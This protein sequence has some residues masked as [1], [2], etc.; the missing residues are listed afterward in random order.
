[1]VLIDTHCHLND[2]PLVRDVPAVL[3]RAR[4]SGVAQVI[5]PAYDQDSWAVVG[6]LQAQPGVSIALGLHPWVATA[7]GDLGPAAAPFYTCKLREALISS[8]AVAVGEIGLD[9]KIEKPDRSA[10]LTVLQSQLELAVELDLPVILHCRGAFE[11]LHAV[12]RRYAPDLRGVLHAFSRGPELAQRFLDL[13]LTVAFG[14]AIT[15]PRAKR[16]RRSAAAV[17]LE[18]IVLET[19]AP[20]IGL[21]GIDAVKTEPCHVRP[22]AAALAAARGESVE[23]IAEVTTTNARK[24]FG[25]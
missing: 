10:Q 9:Y 20:A 12:L 14:G 4:A 8:S 15:R 23:R 7:P 5:V 17:P 19:D 11:E 24:L 1:V 18:R 2:E 22:I 16:A 6:N 13:G 25:I 3:A 21:D